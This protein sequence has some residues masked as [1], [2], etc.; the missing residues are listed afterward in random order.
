[1]DS[2]DK[3][4]Q[5]TRGL[6]AF[7]SG[8]YRAAVENLSEAVEYDESN[9]RAWNA[10]G[11]ACAKVG[12]YAD[13][14]LCFEN[15][16]TLEPD[17]LVYQ[18]NRNTNAKHLKG[19]LLKIGIPSESLL[20][21][22]PFDRIPF[23]LI[24]VDKKYVLAGAIGILI[25]LIIAIL[26]FTGVLFHAQPQSTEKP[27]ILSA[28]L[29]GGSIILTNKGGPEIQSVSFFT[30]KVNDKVISTGEPGDPKA[31]GVKTGSTASVPL[32][33]L[34]G[35]G[36]SNGIRVLV[37]ANYKDGGSIVALN[38]RL[39]PPPGALL[40]RANST[41]E[42]TPTIPP[43][44]PRFS[45]GEVVIDNSTGIW[46]LVT[47]PLENGNYTLAHAARLPNGSFTASDNSVMNIS[48]KAFEKSGQSVGYQGAG[49]TPSGLS[50]LTPPPATGVPT[51]HPDPVYTEGDLI[52]SGPTGSDT[53]II[54]LG[55]DPVTDQYKVDT[56]NKYYTGEWGYRSDNTP[57][58]YIR[59][60]LE[61]QFP[62]RINRIAISDIG[63]G[64]DS[65]PPRTN[66][67]YSAGDI[68]SNDTAGIEDL[69]VIISYNKGPDQYET[70]AIRTAYNG[71]WIRTG[72]TI[73]EKRV[74]VERDHPVKVRNVDLGRVQIG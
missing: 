20:D 39:S 22:P 63:T 73:L 34:M 32:T 6:R 59:P 64:A 46:W 15:A 13:A 9:H 4:G 50:S 67:K 44:I 36:L 35:T 2:G 42:A 61:Q 49:N 52:S 40:P 19:K 3:G 10:L 26:T 37:I 29:S 66:P 57:E 41:L 47:I 45:K 48:L 72:K 12:R 14:D 18:K 23:D 38:T 60:T 56:L 69:A 31:L 7:R 68:I 74:F 65:A 55:Y 1:M 21:R 43:V 70:D 27:I 53:M 71:G 30:W 24:P 62:H 17:N 11:T 16:L 58:W 51:L 28:N 54:V 25:I 8:D 5:F 33:D